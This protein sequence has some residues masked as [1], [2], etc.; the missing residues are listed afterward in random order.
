MVSP[1]SGAVVASAIALALN[2]TLPTAVWG[3]GIVLPGSGPVNR[4]MAGA[5]TAAPLDTLGGLYWNPATLTALPTSRIDIGAELLNSRHV[6]QSF[7]PAGAFGPGVPSSPGF[8]ST[9]G[10][11]GISALPSVGVVCQPEESGLPFTL[12]LGMLTIG[13]YFTNFPG[14]IANPIL[15]PPPPAGVGLGPVYSRLALL[16]MAPTVAVKLSD[17]LSVGLSPTIDL[18]DLQAD[19]FGFA[20]P[21]DANGDGFPSYPQGLHA[22]LRWGLGAQAGVYYQGP[23]CINL[24]V[25]L[26]SPQWFETFTFDTKDELGRPRRVSTRVDYP[27]ILSLGGSYTGV[28]DLVLAC[29][30]RW[31]NYKSTRGFGDPAG[32]DASGAVTGLGWRDVFYLGV[33]AQ[34]Q[35]TSA[36]SL[37]G[38]YSYNTTPIRD[39]SL[40]FS[41]Q[42]PG[43]YQ[44]GLSMGSSLQVTPAL[45]MHA[46]WVHAFNNTLRG[47][48]YSAAGP[49]PGTEL[50]I[51]QSADALVLGISANF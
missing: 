26:K 49:V 47:P 18:A 11:T 41:F 10:D 2:F 42:A 48:I 31:I 19:P 4:S 24:G 30:V 12:G 7:V 43:I 40:F 35:L 20:P 51:K 21:D 1:R 13:G 45:A 37:R 23:R 44:H 36:L 3:Q 8:A 32:I 29:D 46:A 34:Y 38:G 17:C 27:A 33:G 39:E 28:Q 5:S 16:Q 22:R 50:S 15:S 14:T 25:S 9:R 6:A